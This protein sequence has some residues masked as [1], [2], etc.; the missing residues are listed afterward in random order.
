MWLV[1]ADDYPLAQGFWREWDE[2]YELA[3]TK[4]LGRFDQIAP[5]TWANKT[6]M[7]YRRKPG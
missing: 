5:I 4:P 2:Y 7:I 6:V 3:W 1:L